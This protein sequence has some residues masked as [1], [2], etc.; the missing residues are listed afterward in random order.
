MGMKMGGEDLM[1]VKKVNKI[2]EI[3]MRIETLQ[4]LESITIYINNNLI[5]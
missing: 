1:K 5:Y 2:F 4:I 3:P